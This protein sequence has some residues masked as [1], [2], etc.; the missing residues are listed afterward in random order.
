MSVDDILNYDGFWS[1]RINKEH[2]LVYQ[3]EKN[4]IFVFLPEDITHKKSPHLLRY[5]LLLCFYFICL[6]SWTKN[7]NIFYFVKP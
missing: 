5:E 7:F 3:V 2:R 6:L 4:S 1:R